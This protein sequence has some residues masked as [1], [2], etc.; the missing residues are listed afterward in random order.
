M[1]HAVAAPPSALAPLSSTARTWAL[2]L[3]SLALPLSL[4]AF[5]AT[6]RT[7]PRSR[8]RGSR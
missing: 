1:E 5:V 6:G 2:H 3:I 8:C 7:P 4:L